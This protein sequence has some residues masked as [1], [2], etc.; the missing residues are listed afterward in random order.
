MSDIKLER[1]GQPTP[2]AKHGKLHVTGTK[3]LNEKNEI[4]QLRGISTHN[5]SLYPEYINEKAFT[6]F[7]DE[8]GITIIRL[9]MYSAEADDV[10]GYADGSDAHKKELEELVLKGVKIASDLGIYVMID[11]HILLDP[12]PN[13]HKDMAI[14]FFKNICPQLKEYDNVIYEICNEPNK[15]TTWEDI[16]RYANEVIPVIRELDAKKVIIVGTPVW[17]QDV[18]IAAKSPLPYPNL[19]YTLHFYADT[20]KDP[21]RNKLDAALADGLPVFVTEFGICD[22]SG[23]GPIND[24]ET[25]IWIEKLN[26]ND[27]SYIIWNLSCKDETSAILV[28][29]CSKCCDFLPTDYSPCGQR[30]PGYMKA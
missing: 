15:E 19:M 23:N 14:R 1:N 4:C 18:D 11:W 30:V 26:N 3:L 20:H 24:E 22:A 13:T 9:A 12:D 5:L 10:L 25:N 2:F 27:I 17:S 8:M 7:V 16:K 21:L 29:G 6:Q 28:P